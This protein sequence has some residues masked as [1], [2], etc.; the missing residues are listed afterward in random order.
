MYNKINPIS[1]IGFGKL[2]SAM[3]VSFAEKGFDVKVYDKNKSL[4]DKFRTK[5]APF[6]EKMLSQLLKKNFD[7]LYFADNIDTV[8][9]ETDLT[10]LIVPTPIEKNGAYSLKYI[11]D[12]IDNMSNA[13]S[14]KT[15]HSIVLTSTVMPQSCN[16]KIIPYLKKMVPNCQINFFY[17][18][19]FIS[20]GNIIDE[21]INPRLILIGNNKNENSDVLKIIYKKLCG[22]NVKIFQSS[23]ENIEIAKMAVNCT[24]TTRISLMNSF[25]QVCEKTKNADVDDVSEIIKSFF[26]NFDK[27][28]LAGLPYGGPCLP[29]DNIAMGNYFKLKGI[30]NYIP[31]ATDNVNNSIVSNISN[32]LRKKNIKK[33]LILGLSYKNDTPET[34]ESSALD[35]IERVKQDIEITIFDENLKDIDP[36]IIIGLKR[37]ND[38][39]SELQ[40]YETIVLMKNKDYLK[41]YNLN[42]NV[43][44]IDP[45]RLYKKKFTLNKNYIPLGM[46]HEL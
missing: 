32:I 33:L 29:R 18:P 4:I 25:S 17:S 23:I 31:K 9:E 24:M 40:D 16:E 28:F 34:T 35:L 27:G 11:F 15:N 45:W 20:I 6:R 14:K 10:F 13:L 41:N 2:G 37:V 26:L 3:G 1:I 22:G 12:C 38:L 43:L 21:F 19:E 30:Q 39:K 36:K 7:K 5:K 42:Q 8:I 46:Y 44:V